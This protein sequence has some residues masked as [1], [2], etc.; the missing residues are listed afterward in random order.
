[1]A[2]GVPHGEV[3]DMYKLALQFD[4]ELGGVFLTGPER[5]DYLLDYIHAFGRMAILHLASYNPGGTGK[6]AIWGIGVVTKLVFLINKADIHRQMLEHNV[7]LL[8]SKAAYIQRLF[9]IIHFNLLEKPSEA[10]SGP[11][12]FACLTDITAS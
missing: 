3:A 5:V 6:D 9:G 1:M 11:P 10:P 7:Y 2:L 8:Q 12:I 4:P